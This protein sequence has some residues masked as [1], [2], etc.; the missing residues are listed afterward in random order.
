MALTMPALQYDSE[1]SL[2][3]GRILQTLCNAPRNRASVSEGVAS[4]SHYNSAQV[5][6]MGDYPS[7]VSYNE[8]WHARGY[9]CP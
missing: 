2:L 6:G 4:V 8:G 7:T 3:E 1:R 5:A 9:K